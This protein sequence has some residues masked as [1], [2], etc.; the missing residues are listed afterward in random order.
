MKLTN[1][2]IVAPLTDM[3]D[4]CHHGSRKI[5]VHESHASAERECRRLLSFHANCGK[6]YVIYQAVAFARSSL[7][8]VQVC[9]ILDDG[10]V[11]CTE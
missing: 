10:E 3:D 9:D 8:P 4:G 2:F 5:T 6:E 7:P 1:P 11:S